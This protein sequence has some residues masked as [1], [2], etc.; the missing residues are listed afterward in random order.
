LTHDWT[1]WL[2]EPHRV[3]VD[4]RTRVPGMEGK[5]AE[6]RDLHFEYL[7]RLKTQGKLL[8]SGPFEDGTGGML[9]YSANSLEEAI[10]LSNDDPVILDGIYNKP[11]IKPWKVSIYSTKWPLADNGEIRHTGAP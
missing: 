6:Y 2:Q 7:V 10:V 8:M 3:F 9:I 11:N 1:R 4:V 5:L